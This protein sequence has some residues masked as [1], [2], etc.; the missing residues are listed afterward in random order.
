VERR[1]S[2]TASNRV[3]EDGRWL[4]VNFKNLPRGLSS[5]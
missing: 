5:I 3:E 2:R 1:I 4:G